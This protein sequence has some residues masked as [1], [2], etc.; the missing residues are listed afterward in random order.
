MKYLYL[1][2]LAYCLSECSPKNRETAKSQKA[3]ISEVVEIL[4]QEG[5]TVIDSTAKLEVIGTGFKWTEGPVWIESGNY[6]LFS[7]VP[8]NKVYKIDEQGKTSLY[9]HP[10]GY[11]GTTP[12]KNQSGSN[13][14][15]LDHDGTLVLLQPGDRRIARMHSELNNP[16]SSFIT[17]ADNFEGKRFNSPNDGALDSLGNLY[18]TDPPYG[19]PL[20]ENDPAKELSF[21]GVFCLEKNGDLVLLDSLTKPNG[22]ALSPDQSTLYVAVSDKQHAVWYQYD[23]I[24]PAEVANKKVFYDVTHL[25]EKQDHQ[26]LPDG[27]K[28]NR[29]GYLFATGPGG[30]WIFNS[31]ATLVARI[32]TGR[33]TANCALSEDEKRLFI[34]ADDDILMINLK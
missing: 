32:H 10:S 26:G 13:G 12:N 17:L 23:I 18:F 24:T 21:Q 31:K 8:N 5:F 1:I 27:L 14:L 4:D 16:K 30:V 29:K 3:S 15:L 9:L 6:L 11:T 28:V 22:I 19:L 7:D 2:V 33:L 34:T 25:V 20:L